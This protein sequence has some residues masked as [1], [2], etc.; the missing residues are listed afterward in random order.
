MAFFHFQ[1]QKIAYQLQLNE[2]DKQYAVENGQVAGTIVFLHGLGADQRQAIDAA[3]SFAGYQILT[4]DMPGHGETVIEPLENLRY[5]FRFEI[6]SDIILSLLDHLNIDKA[7][8][9]GISMGASI[10]IQVALKQPKR[11]ERLILVRP[12]WL[13]G[14]ALPHLSVVKSIG[15][16]IQQSGI[17]WAEKHLGMQDWFQKLEL[18]NPANANSIKGLFTRPQALAAAA[19]L[20]YLVNDGPFQQLKNLTK[21]K[22]PTVV[23]SNDEDPL[24]PS[25]IAEKIAALIPNARHLKLPS[26]YQHPEDH[27]HQL[28]LLTNLFLRS[29]LSQY[30]KSVLNFV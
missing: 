7:S 23:L 6:F 10:S 27:Q 26:R 15:E 18:N 29:G 24:H 9:G 4:V 2:S 19:V 17:E 12:A 3:S 25:S 30:R 28:T 21:I 11:V 13:N 8:F 20:E 22:Q 5:W 1:E 14:A 16:D